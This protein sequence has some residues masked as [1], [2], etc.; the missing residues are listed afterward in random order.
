MKNRAELAVCAAGAL[1]VTAFAGRAAANGHGQLA[2]VHLP[3]TAQ[4][5]YASS[6]KR[7]GCSRRSR[8]SG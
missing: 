3:N 5:G 6:R 8:C 1:V 4:P 2:Y 7:G